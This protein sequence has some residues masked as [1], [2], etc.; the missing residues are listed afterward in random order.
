MAYKPGYIYFLN[1]R[2]TSRYKIGLTID[3]ERRLKELN[4]QQAAQPIDMI[5]SIRV[6][7]MRSAEKTLHDRF[8]GSQVHGEW[9]EFEQHDLQI[10]Q[11]AYQEVAQQF[12]YTVPKPV[13]KQEQQSEEFTLPG[14]DYNYGGGFD[15][16]AILP[17]VLGVIGLGIFFAN[18][19]GKPRD[20]PANVI[21]VPNNPIN[22]AAKSSDLITTQKANIRQQPN[23][24]IICQVD[25]GTR[26]PVIKFG[27]WS[28]VKACGGKGFIH[29]SVSKG[30]GE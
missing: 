14:Y 7:D 27:E 20:I 23:G 2:G 18:I 13:L 30:L 4:G 16:D 11:S 21:S 3:L 24:K 9:F 1:A 10:V 28:E 15:F 5:W 22:Y 25:R 6:S 8:Q 29:N 12:P 26:L 19:S 17:W